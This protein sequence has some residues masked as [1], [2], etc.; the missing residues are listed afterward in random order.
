[1][2]HFRNI[3]LSSVAAL[4]LA[5]PVA[6]QSS[7]ISAEEFVSG[8]QALANAPERP[9]F[10]NTLS[11]ENATIADGGTSFIAVGV[12]SGQPGAVGELTEDTDGSILIGHTFGDAQRNVGVQLSWGIFSTDSDDFGGEGAFSV[13]FSRELVG[14]AKPLYGALTLS[15]L[16]AYGNDKNRE[17][18]EAATL[19]LTHFNS[20]QVGNEVLPIM[21]TVGYGTQVKTAPL[22]AGRPFQ[23]DPGFFAG[24]GVGLTPNFGVSI[25]GNNSFASVGTAFRFDQVK[26]TEFQLSVDDVFDDIDQ[27]R[28]TLNVIYSTQDLFGGLR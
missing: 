18:D 10:V 19:S 22:A 2:A 25:A 7:D 1:M 5:S 20:L 3:L 11:V 15:N 16:L 23:R 14:G 24:V 13:K 6:A 4:G 17:L 12:S 28:I 9:K 27:R 21:A 8:I 26:N